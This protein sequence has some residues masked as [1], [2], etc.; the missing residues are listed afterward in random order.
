M[1]HSVTRMLL[2]RQSNSFKS[3]F[4]QKSQSVHF[5]ILALY[6]RIK[7][8]SKY[9]GYKLVRQYPLSFRPRLSD[10][11]L[12]AGTTVRE[13]W[14]PAE[15]VRVILLPAEPE[16]LSL[17]RKHSVGRK[18]NHAGRHGRKPFILYISLSRKLE[19]ADYLVGSQ[20]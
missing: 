14:L 11:M 12:P 8:I 9:T 6:W 20:I 3:S 5:A 13:K 16:C 17:G 2:K 10:L 15:T 7:L 19:I 1:I 4:L 18:Q